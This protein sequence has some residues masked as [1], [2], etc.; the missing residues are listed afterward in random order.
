MRE[1]LAPPYTLLIPR[2]CFVREGS[3][4]PGVSKETP[5]DLQNPL[6]RRT[7]LIPLWCVVR[8]GSPRPGVSKEIP[9]YHNGGNAFS[10][11]LKPPGAMHLSCR[12]P[13]WQPL[14]NPKIPTQGSTCDHVITC[15]FRYPP[16]RTRSIIM[17]RKGRTES[18]EDQFN[19]SSVPL[20]L[21][22]TWYT[23][24][25][26]SHFWEERHVYLSCNH[27]QAAAVE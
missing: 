10:Q 17:S 1:P 4:R 23:A 9:D 15:M 26:R 5:D 21:T 14:T 13:I 16:G 8:V 24:S 11:I 19:M 7:T 27:G 2:W 25:A 3:P 12:G 18:G 6:H 20:R 22:V